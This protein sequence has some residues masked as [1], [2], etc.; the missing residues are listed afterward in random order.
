MPNE[1]LTN[2]WQDNACAQCPALSQC[3]TQVVVASPCPAGGLLA[4]G[5]APGGDE[6][7]QG[8]GFVG[9]AGKTLDRLLA[10]E[11]VSRADYGRA[12]ICRCRPLENRKPKPAEIT[13]CLPFLA[14]LIVECQPS[15]LLLVGGTAT[16]HIMGASTLSARIA[17]ANNTT[18]NDLSLAHP[19]LR[20]GLAPL[21][22][23]QGG[24]HCVPMPHTSPLAFNRNAPSG[25]KWARV[26][27]R[28]V[29]LAVSLLG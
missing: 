16:A 20:K 13:A 8:E 22:S 1:L 11:G 7:L 17:Q 15:V 24:V 9:T 18:F 21:L 3:R 12:N 29:A 2:H 25:E 6:D 23:R 4:I 19:V 14:N 26:A 28:Q 10:A 27:E 5:E